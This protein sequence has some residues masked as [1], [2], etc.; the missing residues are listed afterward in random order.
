MVYW[1]FEQVIEDYIARR[2]EVVYINEDRDKVYITLR[3]VR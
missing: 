2:L 3:K 1:Y